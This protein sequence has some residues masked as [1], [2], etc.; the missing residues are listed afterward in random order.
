MKF[1]VAL[2][3]IV[4]GIHRLSSWRNRVDG[5]INLCSSVSRRTT[6][7][8]TVQGTLWPIGDRTWRMLDPK[9]LIQDRL[10]RFEGE[11]LLNRTRAFRENGLSP[12]FGHEV[13]V[14]GAFRCEVVRRNPG[15]LEDGF[16]FFTP[17]KLWGVGELTQRESLAPTAWHVRFSSRFRAHL[18]R[19]FNDTPR[20]RGWVLAVWTGDS[21]GLDPFLRQFYLEG[22]LLQIIALSGQ[23]VVILVLLIQTILRWCILLF[24]WVPE[25]TWRLYPWIQRFLPLGCALLLWMTG[26]DSPPVRRTVVMIFA[27]TCLSLRRL[28]CSPLQLTA[29]CVGAMILW[30][31]DI[32][33]SLSFFLSAVATAILCQVVAGFQRSS[34]LKSYFCLCT[35]MPIL[36][37]PLTAFFFAKISWLAPLNN[38]V[39]AWLW[40]LLL[41]PIGFLFPCIVALFPEA[42]TQPLCLWLERRWEDLIEFHVWLESALGTT[43]LSCI[44]PTWIEFIIVELALVWVVTKIQTRAN[45]KFSV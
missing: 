12:D 8:T 20:V 4:I 7:T 28:E 11:V 37:F 10:E 25:T 14:S 16:L 41:I 36:V 29:S 9:I 42:I 39:L 18:D 38:L 24:Q 44:R 3:L 26:M 23:H 32:L 35:V 43:Y 2:V 45:P 31:P 17:P 34:K 1:W 21:S 33:S 27:L 15:R 22:G 40:D 5:A 13:I 6:K 19:L 30:H